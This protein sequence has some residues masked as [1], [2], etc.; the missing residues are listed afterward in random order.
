MIR[1][2]AM[3]VL[4]APLLAWAESPQETVAF[5]DMKFMQDTGKTGAVM[6]DDRGDNC[7]RWAGLYV[8]EVRVRQVL[9]GDEPPRKFI[10]TFSKHALKQGNFKRVMARPEKLDKPNADTGATYHIR[11]W[12]WPRELYCFR[13][14]PDAKTGEYKV[15]K[16]GEHF[17]CY[18]LKN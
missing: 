6:C 11:D 9:A 16:E 2:L 3:L 1:V 18:E 10:A 8:F 15:E 14:M 7:Q 5:I 12:A 4:S 13:Q 17:G